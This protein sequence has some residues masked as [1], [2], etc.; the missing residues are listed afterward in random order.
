MDF[1][2]PADYW[3]K[4]KESEKKDRYLDVVMELKKLWNMKVTVIPIVTGALGT[5]TRRLV[6]ET[7][8]LRNKRTCGDHLN[9]CIIKIGQNTEKCPG[10]LRRI[11]VTQT[12][13]K[14]YWPTLVGKLEKK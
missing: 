12:P 6:Q 11:A 14:N 8:G 5:I 2:V 9:Y 3:V 7:G 4:L 10:D 13:V 1:P